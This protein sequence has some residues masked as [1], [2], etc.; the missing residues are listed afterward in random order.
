MLSG[1]SFYHR[2]IRKNVIAFGTVFNDITLKRFNYNTFTETE[3]F[4]VPLVYSP[5]ETFITK[6]LG[7]PNL[8]RNTQIT[9][10]RMSFEMTSIAYDASRKLS[11][12]NQTF[13]VK[14]NSKLDFLRSGVPYTIGFELNIYARNVE[15]G[16]QIIEQILPYFEPDYTVSINFIDNIETKRDVPIILNDVSYSQEYEGEKGTVRYLVWTLNFSMKTYFYTGTSESSLIRKTIANTSFELEN[17]ALRQ[18]ILE[19]NCIF[20]LGEIVYQGDNLPTATAIGR[21]SSQTGNTITIQVQ[22]GSFVENVNLKGD[23]SGVICNIVQGLN[24][25]LQIVYQSVTPDP[26]NAAANGDFGFTNVLQE[27]PYINPVTSNTDTYSGDSFLITADTQL[28]TSDEE[29]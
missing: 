29:Q 13:Y 26:L 24:N 17:T 8:Q 20:K 4:K 23:D 27:Y 1:S 11:S 28:L 19:N 2:I 22:T 18:F 5:K 9:L 25:P 6:L 12:F 21:V 16:T 3:R 7:D 15:D 14:S 10:P